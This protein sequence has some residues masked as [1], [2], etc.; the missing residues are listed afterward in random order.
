MKQLTLASLFILFIAGIS[1]T[2]RAESEKPT[3]D[4]LTD[5][6]TAAKKAALE[7]K[8]LLVRFG[9]EWCTYCKRM[10]HYAFEDE[11]VVPRIKEHFVPVYVDADLHPSLLPKM[12]VKVLPSF[13]VMTP[14]MNIVDRSSGYKKEKEFLAFIEPHCKMHDIAMQKAKGEVPGVEQVK[15]QGFGLNPEIAKMAPEVSSKGKALSLHQTPPTNEALRKEFGPPTYERTRNSLALNPQAGNQNYELNQ[16]PALNPAFAMNPS[17][18]M[19][20]QSQPQ[21]PAANSNANSNANLN[22]TES[23]PT[24]HWANTIPQSGN[25]SALHN[26]TLTPDQMALGQS[27]NQPTFA[28]LAT[29]QNPFQKAIVPPQS[30][31]QLNQGQQGQQ[32][33]PQPPIATQPVAQ[34]FAQQYPT[35]M[36]PNS[37]ESEAPPWSGVPAGVAQAPTAQPNVVQVPVAQFQPPQNLNTAP[38]AVAQV[39]VTAPSL[40]P[41]YVSNYEQEALKKWP[42]P[43][44][45]AS[46]SVPTAPVV[47]NQVVLNTPVPPTFAPPVANT[48][49]V[50][51]E[52]KI[53]DPTVKDPPW[54]TTPIATNPPVTTTPVATSPVKAAPTSTVTTLDTENAEPK[55]PWALPQ[56]PVVVTQNH[57]VVKTTTVESPF[58]LPVAAPTAPVVTSPVGTTQSQSAQFPVQNHAP[59]ATTVAPVA[60]VTPD[61]SIPTSVATAKKSTETESTVNPFAA[62]AMAPPPPAEPPMQKPP[63]QVQTVA[64][65]PTAQSPWTNSFESTTP[66]VTATPVSST[67]TVATIKLSDRV[68]VTKPVAVEVPVVPAA[69]IPAPVKSNAPQAFYGMCIVSV[70]EDGKLVDGKPEI[71]TEYHGYKLNF[72]DRKHLDLFLTNPARYWPANNGLCPVSGIDKQSRIM[73]QPAFAVRYHNRVHFCADRETAMTFLNGPQKYG[74]YLAQ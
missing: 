55:S 20:P 59:W 21:W 50:V 49:P 52:Q 36:P 54:G 5:I 48:A 13:V 12:G 24:S 10:D 33:Q 65:S 69:V 63:V 73:G 62:Y 38:I 26:D 53:F 6:P 58:A 47:S 16:N 60:P 27:V 23:A 57:P 28:Q 74:D 29:S 68:P 1:L 11:E 3:V 43:A 40:P 51:A 39:P 70:L 42:V 66:E 56:E 37:S 72:V 22:A 30:Q 71:S 31:P 46:T 19:M 7:G 45:V 14:L 61:V 32:I 2:L 44:P 8:P 67:T 9:A 64:T 15:A 34:S 35:F 17:P 18:N 25:N 41:G 4:W